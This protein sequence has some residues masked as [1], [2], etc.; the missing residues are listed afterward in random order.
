MRI[1]I[2]GS[3]GRLGSVL[4]SMFTSAGHIVVGIDIFNAGILDQEIRDADI[5]LLAVPIAESIGLLKKYTPVCP[6][7]ET[8]SVKRPFKEFRNVVISIHPLFGPLSV[9]EEGMNNIAFIRDISPAGSIEIVRSL[10]PDFN[11][12][13][14]TAEDH[15][16]LAIQLQVIPYIISILSS[17]LMTDTDVSTRSRNALAALARVSGAQNGEV[18]KDTI[19]LNPFS[20]IAFTRILETLNE[21]GGEYID[22]CPTQQAS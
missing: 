4:S 3:R 20:K 10:F 7:I 13:S 12:I 22:S 8:S 5:A 18:L 21:I 1:I 16:Q 14:M 9:D 17:R 2:I 6:I 15:D 11:I 19:R